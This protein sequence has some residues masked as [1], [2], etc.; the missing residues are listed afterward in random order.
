MNLLFSETAT[1]FAFGVG[2]V[3]GGW[4]GEQGGRL[5]ILQG[6]V[7]EV[8]TESIFKILTYSA[9]RLLHCFFILPP[10]PSPK[11]SFLLTIK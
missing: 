2:G 11:F 5:R 7:E 4:R 8:E 9:T 3:K 10:R 1:E 6:F